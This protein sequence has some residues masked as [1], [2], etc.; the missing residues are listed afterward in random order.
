MAQDASFA[1]GGRLQLD[2][3]SADLSNPDSTIED[4]EVRRARLKVFGQLGANTEY[5]LQV[6]LDADGV[7]FEDAL[8]EYSPSGGPLMLT[9]G[10]HKTHNSLDEQ[11]SSRFI[12][13]LE[14][15]AFTD[16]FD[17][18]RLVGFSLG[19]SGPTH[20]ITAGIFTTN[21]EENDGGTALAARGTFNPIKTDDT[22]VHLG[23]SWRSRDKGDDSADLRYR[24][25]PFTHVAP[26]RIIDTGR[27][28]KADS[29]FGVE[30]AVLHQQF[31]AAGEYGVAKAQGAGLNPDADLKGGYTEVGYFWGGNKTYKG[32]KFNRPMVD[33]PVG[34]GGYGAVS[35]VA[36]FDSIDL[37]DSLYVGKLDTT[38]LGVD[39]WPTHNTRASLNFFDANATNGTADSASGVVLRAQFDF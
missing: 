26:S 38:I 13:T 16:A 11:T 10:Q 36:R 39:W 5:K 28:A 17:F 2:Y 4:E 21:L 14:R 37:Q 20:S 33:A 27:F 7:I 35:V 22:I 1:I 31:W 3:T 30:A 25:R 6:S 8:I 34:K 9:V 12:S 18:D 24:Q 32:N 15:A 23:A 29:F 19:H